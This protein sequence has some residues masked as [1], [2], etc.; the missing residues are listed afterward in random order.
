[1]PTPPDVTVCAV[2]ACVWEASARKAGNVHRDRDFSGLSYLD[3]LQSAAAIGPAFARAGEQRVGATVLEALQATRRVVATNTNLG[4]VLLLAPL[5][6][7]PLDEPLGTGIGTVLDRLTIEDSRDVY[8]AIRLA[9]PG[10]MGDAPE[11]DVKAEPTLPLREAMALAQDRD[12]IA[13]QYANGFRE[14]LTDGV[15]ALVHHSQKRGNLEDA[16]V[17]THLHLMSRYPDSLIARKCGVAVAEDAGRR[18]ADVLAGRA[19]YADLDAWLRADGN[20]RNPGTSADLVTACLFAALREGLITL[21]CRWS[22]E[23]A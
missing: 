18:A 13:R 15:P 5:A 12:L 3:F 14:V 17:H 11:Q 10:G 2:L 21:P 19:A 23:R 16:I 7:V 9:Q 6:T 1:M 22:A 8:T 4:I 20:A